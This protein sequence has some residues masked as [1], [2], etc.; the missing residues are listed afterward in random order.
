MAK[1]VNK[2]RNGNILTIDQLLKRFKKEVIKEGK[3]VAL[4]KHQ[5]FIPKSLA[6][7][8]KSKEHQRLMRNLSKKQ[9]RR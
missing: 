5:F 6:R 9:A 8:I 2:D 4:K 1:V 3:L 7:R